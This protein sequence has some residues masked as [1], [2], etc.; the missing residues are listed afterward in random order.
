MRDN[1]PQVDRKDWRIGF[2]L[3]RPAPEGL[4]PP[5]GPPPR[6]WPRP[7]GGAHQVA[8]PTRLARGPALFQICLRSLV[9]TSSAAGK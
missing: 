8:P 4:A 3:V 6:A 7:E 2:Q 1:N 5:P 9:A